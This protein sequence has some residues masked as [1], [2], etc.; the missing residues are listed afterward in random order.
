MCHNL[1]PCGP[2]LFQNRFKR[3]LVIGNNA[4]DINALGYQILDGA[5]LQRGVRTGWP[6]HR[7]I[8]AKCRALF[9][10]PGFH[11]VKP[12]NTPD[13]DHNPHGRLILCKGTGCQGYGNRKPR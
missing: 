13:L 6:D 5:H 7:G 11:R 10:D 4:N 12:G 9:L 3:R 2:R 1:D 8:N